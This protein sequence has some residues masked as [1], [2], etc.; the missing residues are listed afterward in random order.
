M[1]PR[2]VRLLKNRPRL[3]DFGLRQEFLDELDQIATERRKPGRVAERTTENMLNRAAEAGRGPM[4][5]RI[6]RRVD[7]INGSI[8]EN[9]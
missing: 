1:R 2:I 8:L 4:R 5:R 7:E 9:L 6:E 3:V